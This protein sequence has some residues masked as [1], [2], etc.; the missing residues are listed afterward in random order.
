MNWYLAKMIF[1]V[2][3]GEG[4]HTPQFDEQLRLI[5]ADDEQMAFEKAK[6]L[7]EIEQDS[8]YNKDKK[9]VQ[10][11]FIGV[12]DVYPLVEMIDG[13]ELYSR[14]QEPEDPETYARTIHHKAIQ[15]Q[16]RETPKFFQLLR[17]YVLL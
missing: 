6:A 4:L 10:W 15:F 5:A 3:C 11:K 14:I 7:G 8:F 1:Q 12:E 16:S 13:A 9:L 2:I 17:D